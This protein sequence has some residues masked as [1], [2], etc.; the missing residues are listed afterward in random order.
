MKMY[1]EN[2]DKLSAEYDREKI[3]IHF[4]DLHGNVGYEFVPISRNE[5]EMVME[6][7]AVESYFLPYAPIYD[8][9]MEYIRAELPESRLEIVDSEKMKKS[10]EE[11]ERVIEGYLKSLAEER[12]RKKE[13][14]E[15]TL[16][17]HIQGKAV[18]LYDLIARSVQKGVKVL[19]VT[20]PNKSGTDMDEYQIFPGDYAYFIE[21]Y[22]SYPQYTFHIKGKLRR[23]GYS[24]YIP[25]DEIFSAD[26]EIWLPQWA[27]NYSDE[28]LDVKE[29]FG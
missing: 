10:M 21:K 27:V 14:R 12:E 25:V 17:D 19:I 7:V 2:F 13:E 29:V 26:K 11:S 6:G 4:L 24:G 15:E 9:D 5:P 22:A 8:K 16:Y 23:S 3:E 28:K 20:R 1:L 18:T